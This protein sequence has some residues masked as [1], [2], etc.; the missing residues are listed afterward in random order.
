MFFNGTLYIV[1]FL[2]GLNQELYYH[3]LFGGFGHLILRYSAVSEKK[4][5]YPHSCG[6][7]WKMNCTEILGPVINIIKYF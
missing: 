3:I 5:L 4:W 6:Q 7:N 2:D 1:T